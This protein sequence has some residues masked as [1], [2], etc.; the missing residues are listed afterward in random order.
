MIL[1]LT[2]H[3]REGAFSMAASAADKKST[4]A[5]SLGQ[6][7]SRASVVSDDEEKAL[8]PGVAGGV[9]STGGSPP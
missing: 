4:P 8:L 3:C 2:L 7:A 9:G 1:L 6:S 5:K